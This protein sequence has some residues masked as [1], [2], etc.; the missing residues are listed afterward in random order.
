MQILA[1]ESFLSRKERTFLAFYNIN[2]FAELINDKY[3]IRQGLGS[4]FELL[5]YG[6]EHLLNFL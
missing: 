6:E 4:G 2:I 3:W 5:V 1:D